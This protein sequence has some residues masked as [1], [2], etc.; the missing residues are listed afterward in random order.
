MSKDKIKEIFTLS[1]LYKFS[2]SLLSFN[3]QTII[4][5]YKPSIWNS[6]TSN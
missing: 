4:T 3:M 5:S 1:H 2:I 6:T